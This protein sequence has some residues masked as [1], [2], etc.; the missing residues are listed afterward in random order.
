M[1][2]AFG[3]A[4]TEL[5][6]EVPRLVV[7]DADVSK[8]TRT[9]LFEQAFPDRFFN[10]G[11]AEQNMV[12]VAAGL[13]TMGFIPVISSFAFLLSLRAA[14]QVR[15]SVAYPRLNVKLIGGYCGLSDAKDGPTHQSVM[16]L[17]VMR[18]MPNMRVVCASDAATVRSALRAIVADDG[19]WY[20][21]VSRAE[22]PDIF[23]PET[24]F[25]LGKARLVSDAGN[26]CAILATGTL[27]SNALAAQRLLEARHVHVKVAEMH[28][29]KPLDRD[30]VLQM[31]RDTG[32]IVTVEEHS[33]IGGLGSAVCEVLAEAAPV[34]VVRVG[35]RDA[36]AESGDIEQLH[37][38][39][40]LDA[41]A[42]VSAVEL[43]RRTGRKKQGGTEK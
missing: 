34:R 3:E 20:L 11:V 16:D 40:G 22:V 32:C 4:L 27:L 15:T 23:P 9:C 1:R 36:F 2:E 41:D 21:R 42:I 17:A 38:V 10:C 28:T 6:H 31:A 8:S 35:L 29:L 12:G 24:P 33:V 39:F 43:C 25:T 14:E 26:D 7:L 19:P 37:K 30:F 18:A 5:G 13:S